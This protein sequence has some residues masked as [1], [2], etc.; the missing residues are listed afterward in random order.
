MKII[1]QKEFKFFLKTSLNIYFADKRLIFPR[2]RIKQAV[3]KSL[4]QL[5]LHY[6]INKLQQKI[7]NFLQFSNYAM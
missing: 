2:I 3:Q 5:K 7:G 6:H 4:F 1:Y